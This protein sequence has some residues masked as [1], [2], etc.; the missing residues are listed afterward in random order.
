M[1]K[2]GEFEIFFFFL[3]LEISIDNIAPFHFGEFQV[4]S[5]HTKIFF[6]NTRLK[7]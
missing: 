4:V 5:I 6:I 3:F 7:C 1:G 2:I